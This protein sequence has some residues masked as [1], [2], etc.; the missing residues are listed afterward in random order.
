MTYVRKDYYYKKAKEE[1]KASRASYKIAQLQEKYKFLKKGDAVVDLGCA[2]G[3]WLQELVQILGPQGKVV[4][5]DILPLKISTHANVTFL[6]QSIE[7]EN[8]ADTLFEILGRKADAVVSDMAPNTSGVA[9]ADAYRSYELCLLGFE[10]C[11]KLLRAGG[12]FICKIF[13]GA[14]LPDFRKMLQQHFEKVSSVVPPATRKSSSEI[15][16]V[17]LGYKQQNLPANR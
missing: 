10:A 17:C 12:T 14:E 8:I 6:L 2:P 16:L 5:I 13:P 9:F 11:E 15:Y 7:D 4:G 1:G 3:G